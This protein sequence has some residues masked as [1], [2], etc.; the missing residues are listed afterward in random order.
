MGEKKSTFEWPGTNFLFP[1]HSKQAFVVLIFGK[2]L[3]AFQLFREVLDDLRFVRNPFTR[4][5]YVG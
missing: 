3:E 5:G 1:S 2:G 4:R